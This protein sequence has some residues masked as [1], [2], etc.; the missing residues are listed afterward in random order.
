MRVVVFHPDRLLAFHHDQRVLPVYALTV[1]KDGPKFHESTEEDSARFGCNGGVHKLCRHVTMENL[2]TM[3]TRFSRM[4][5]PG[6]LDRPVVDMTGLTKT[7]D[8][9]FDNG[10]VGGG[11]GAGGGRGTGDPPADA[12]IISAFDGVKA[13]GLKLDPAKHTYDILV[14]NHV[15]RVPTEN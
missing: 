5:S 12:E 14:I 7:Y 13:L 15:E 9:N 8:F 10:R 2:A 11:R 4:G 1:G 6:A 3:L